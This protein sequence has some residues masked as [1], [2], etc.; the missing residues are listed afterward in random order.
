M[1]WVERNLKDY[2]V[3][4][5]LPWTVLPITRLGCPEPHPILP[6]TSPGMGNETLL[7]N[8]TEMVQ[9]NFPAA[10]I[11]SEWDQESETKRQKEKT[12]EKFSLFPEKKLPH[13]FLADSNRMRLWGSPLRTTE[14]GSFNSLPSRSQSL[15]Q[16]KAVPKRMLLL[17]HQCTLLFFFHTLNHKVLHILLFSVTSL[18]PYPFPLPLRQLNK[19]LTSSP[20]SYAAVF[21]SPYLCL[22]RHSCECS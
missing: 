22:L 12:K 14:T 10:A 8:E 9:R 13:I 3:P 5:P 18:P 17:W 19:F 11:T 15:F 1:A 7:W 20:S 2:P 6:C 21:H 4:M 16:N